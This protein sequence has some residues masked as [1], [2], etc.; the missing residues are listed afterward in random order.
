MGERS[1]VCDLD[2]RDLQRSGNVQ[3]I[4]G[5]IGEQKQ[6]NTDGLTLASTNPHSL[7]PSAPAKLVLYLTQFYRARIRRIY[8]H[9]LVVMD[10]QHFVPRRSPFLITFGV[11]CMQKP[12]FV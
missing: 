7:A 1:L 2:L 12:K 8:V 9:T 3:V 6:K 10:A 4:N 5:I 11:V